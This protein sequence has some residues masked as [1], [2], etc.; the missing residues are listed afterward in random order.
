MIIEPSKLTTEIGNLQTAFCRIIM[1][2]M[3]TVNRLTE[4]VNLQTN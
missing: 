1:E 4:A 2:I 3:Q